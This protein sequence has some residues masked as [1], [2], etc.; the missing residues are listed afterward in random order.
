VFLDQK[1]ASRCPLVLVSGF[2][3]DVEEFKEMH[4]GG[5]SILLAH[6]GKDATA[7]FFGGTYD[8]SNAAHNVSARELCPAECLLTGIPGLV[9]INHASRRARRRSRAS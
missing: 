8:H 9:V 6:V 2:I 7:A 4:P 1:Q 3:H 5:K